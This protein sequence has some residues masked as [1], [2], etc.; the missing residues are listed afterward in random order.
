M[1]KSCPCNPI[2]KE[3][4]EK[5]IVDATYEALSAN[6]NISLL[7]DKILAANKKRNDDESILKLLLSEYS[8]TDKAINNILTAMEQGVFTASTKERLEQLEAKKAELNEKLITEKAKTKLSI[9]KSDIMK[10]ILTA[11][12]KDPRPMVDALIKKVILYN[13]KIEIHYNY[14]STKNPD[15][16]D[17]HRDFIFYTCTKSFDVDQRKMN[18]QPIV[19]TFTIQLWI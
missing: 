14:T 3:L 4:I 13:D 19:L 6:E 1:D 7:A 17:N 10:F 5:I 2:R 18:T 8:E 11:L 15:G 9:T 16:T 12:R